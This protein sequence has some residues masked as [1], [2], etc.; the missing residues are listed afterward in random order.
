MV[1]LLVRILPGYANRHYTMR[2]V[3]RDLGN[4]LPRFSDI[5]TLRAEALFTENN[6]HYASFQRFRWQAQKPQILVVA[7]GSKEE[8]TVLTQE[9]TLI[10]KYNLY[11][12]PEYSRSGLNS[13]EPV[14]E[15]I[16]I[17]VYKKNGVA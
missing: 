5:T 6:L 7:F 11:V 15:G 16:T 9:Y 3:S 8:E 1:V 17:R 2:D 4:L 12:A 10:K 14:S 13:S